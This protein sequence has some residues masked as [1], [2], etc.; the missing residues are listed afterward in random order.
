MKLPSS[1]NNWLSI[2]GAILALFNLATILS[3]MIPVV[4]MIHAEASNGEKEM[5]CA[6]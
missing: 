3:L 1:V 4:I 5:E 2:T 6:E